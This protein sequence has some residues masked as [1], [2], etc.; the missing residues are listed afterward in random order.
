MLAPVLPVRSKEDAVVV[1]IVVVAIT[2][3]SA[4]QSSLRGKR[5][6]YIGRADVAQL[7]EHFTR[8]EGVPGSSPGVGFSQPGGF[9]PS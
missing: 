5:L 2:V 6:T 4:G 1:V 9:R 3:P 7:V 8:N